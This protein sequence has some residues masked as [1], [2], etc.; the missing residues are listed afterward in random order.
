MVLQRFIEHDLE[1]D[2]STSILLICPQVLCLARDH[3]PCIF[4]SLRFRPAV[5][6]CS[7]SVSGWTVCWCFQES[8]CL[9]Q[10]EAVNREWTWTAWRWWWRQ[11][12]SLKPHRPHSLTAWPSWRLGSSAHCSDNLQS[13]HFSHHI[14]IPFV[15][16]LSVFLCHTWLPGL[17]VFLCHAW[18]PVVWSNICKAQRLKYIISFMQVDSGWPNQPNYPRDVAAWW[19]KC[20][21]KGTKTSVIKVLKVTYG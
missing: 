14:F 10:C 19:F 1:P 13:G 2:Q 7:V 3:D 5:M 8:K 21:S 18:L 6:L 16:G 15:I 20:G 4:S 11:Y 9:L 17:S 12:N